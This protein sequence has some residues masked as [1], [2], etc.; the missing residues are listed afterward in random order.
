MYSPPVDDAYED[1]RPQLQLYLSWNSLQSLPPELWGLEHLTVLSLRN[2]ELT[3]ISPSIARL[4]N[5]VELN[6]A[7]NKF[8]LL[9]WE[10][11]SFS[12]KDL[13]RLAVHPNPSLLQGI[14]PGNSLVC[15]I[16][17][18]SNKEILELPKSLQ[19]LDEKC[20]SL[21][22]AI[23]DGLED[24]PKQQATWLL[25][26]L[27]TL[28][29]RMLGDE[30]DGAFD[31]PQRRNMA[32]IFVASSPITYLAID[33]TPFPNDSGNQYSAPQRGKAL[34]ME[35]SATSSQVPSLLELSLRSANQ[36]IKPDE[37][38][39]YLPDPMPVP[40]QRSLS[41]ARSAPSESTVHNAC[42]S[43][44][45]CGRAYIIPRAEWV[46][47]WHWGKAT[48][49]MWKGQKSLPH[50]FRME[51]MFLPFQRKACSWGCAELAWNK[52]AEGIEI[53]M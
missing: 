23:A 42:R 10:L 14:R 2:N 36:Y 48:F 17:Q 22:S 31:S 49:K 39:P 26:V 40:L 6:L 21:E 24:D 18:D 44:T 15:K 8:Q 46:E 13:K 4:R 32:P 29:R 16:F 27:Q 35:D 33:G 5:L 52:N 11:L 51:E 45:V 53:E 38:L 34:S 9:P 47:Y 43:C 12:K 20:S 28:R 41:L 25:R 7:G 50:A 37:M 1:L 30:E 19:H 3:E